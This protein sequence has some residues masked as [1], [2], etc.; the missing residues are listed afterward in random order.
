[1]HVSF[2]SRCA[3]S[4]VPVF[5]RFLGTSFGKASHVAPRS[6]MSGLKRPETSVSGAISNRSVLR[7][8]P[9]SRSAATIRAPLAQGRGG[10]QA[11]AACTGASVR[12]CGPRAVEFG[13]EDT[14]TVTT[15]HNNHATTAT[16]LYHDS[17]KHNRHCSHQPQR[18]SNLQWTE[19]F[20]SCCICRHSV[21]SRQPA[22]LAQL[23]PNSRVTLAESACGQ[24]SH[25]GTV[26]GPHHR[27][28]QSA[29]NLSVAV[30]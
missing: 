26:P 14:T 7:G 8:A 24:V 5:N 28:C 11:E 29:V 27:L 3:A 19:R 13:T 10:R 4:C 25:C 18:A 1:M 9:T 22:A 23:P 16:A 15:D 20:V 12:A 17:H 2:F 21:G 6:Y 30:V